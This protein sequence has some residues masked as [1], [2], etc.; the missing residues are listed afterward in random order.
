MSTLLYEHVYIDQRGIPRV[1]EI[2]MKVIH[3]VMMQQAHGYSSA[4]LHFQ[5]PDLS[6]G[7]IHAAF[8]YYWD[9]KAE[10]D[11]DIEQH[12]QYVEQVRHDWS[13]SEAVKRLRSLDYLS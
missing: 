12:D 5:F 9:R 1:G 8:A 13:E 4:E 2:G 6:M 10:L 11:A 7:E 3:L